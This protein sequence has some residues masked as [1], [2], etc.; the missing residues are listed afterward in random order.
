AID[1]NLLMTSPLAKGMFTR[2]VCESGTLLVENG[3]QSL[4]AA[5][6]FGVKLAEAAKLPSGD[7]AANS[8]P[9]TT[10]A[11]SLNRRAVVWMRLAGR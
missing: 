3:G 2:V 7:G 10:Q 11:K 5:E 6:Q 1:S 9:S 4:S 8:I